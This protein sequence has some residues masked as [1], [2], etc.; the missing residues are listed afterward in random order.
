MKDYNIFQTLTDGSNKTR[1]WNLIRQLMSFNF[2]FIWNNLSMWQWD[3]LVWMPWQEFT[4]L[5]HVFLTICMWKCEAT[6]TALKQ[7]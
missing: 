4:I 3:N 6:A 1:P 5:K 7:L 2:M